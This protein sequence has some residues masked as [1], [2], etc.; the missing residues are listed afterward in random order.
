MFSTSIASVQYLGT[1]VSNVR[2]CLCNFHARLS[3]I[4]NVI[5]NIHNNLG[6]R[7]YSIIQCAFNRAL[8]SIIIQ[9][10]PAGIFII[11]FDLTASEHENV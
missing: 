1:F 9:C 6:N 5:G 2:S 3:K 11:Q 8:K 4:R 10:N 7:A